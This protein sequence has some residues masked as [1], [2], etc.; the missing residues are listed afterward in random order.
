[1]KTITKY[2]L[3][4]IKNNKF[5]INRK[6]RTN[7]FLMPGGKPEQGESIE[8]CLIREIKEEHGCTIIQNSISFFDSFEDVAA[9]E[10]NTRIHMKLYLGKIK[11][12]PQ[13]R[14]EIEECRWFGKE[15]NQEILSPIIKNK[16]LPLLLKKK[17]IT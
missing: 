5:L 3:L 9:N 12:E 16:I 2:G 4:I 14:S 15:D 6:K 11:G 10:P 17:I 1:M 13:T 8:E 7:L